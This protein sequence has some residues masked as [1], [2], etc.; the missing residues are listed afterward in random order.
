[1][2][3]IKSFQSLVGSLLCIS[4]CTRPDISFV[5]HRAT[6]RTHAPTIGDCTVAKRILKYL[7]GTSGLRLKLVHDE[8]LPLALRITCY[9]KADFA[10]GNEDRKSVNGMVIF[11]NGIVVT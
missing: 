7:K 2:P 11:V 8:K 5:L 3:C 4:R 10:A 6:G 9:S 1:M